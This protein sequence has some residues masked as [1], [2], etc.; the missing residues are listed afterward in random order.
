[1][2]L[3]IKKKE[4]KKTTIG[5]VNIIPGYLSSNFK[6]EKKY[7]RLFFNVAYLTKDKAVAKLIHTSA[8]PEVA[9]N[10]Y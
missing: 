8:L 3:W 2:E 10:S 1:M 5:L 7:L 4:R 6:K 9:E